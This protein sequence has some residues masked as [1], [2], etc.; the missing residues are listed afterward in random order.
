M[1][2]DGRIER[3]RDRIRLPSNGMGET[4]FKKK[5][6]K[7]LTGTRPLAKPTIETAIWTI[8]KGQELCCIKKSLQG[9]TGRTK[10]SSD[11][12]VPAPRQKRGKRQKIK[13]K[14]LWAQSIR[15]KR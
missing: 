6:D 1:K 15:R 2:R 14:G 12:K 4:R 11:E 13:Q 8:T 3:K 5:A 9:D 7:R 10:S